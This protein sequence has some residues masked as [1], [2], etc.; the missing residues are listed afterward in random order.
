[1][2]FVRP[3]TDPMKA[4][5]GLQLEL[6]QTQAGPK[7]NLVTNQ[8]RTKYEPSTNQVKDLIL[9]VSDNYLSLGD[10][11]RLCGLKSRMRFR[12]TYILPAL[13]ENAIERKYPDIPNHPRQQY[14]LTEQAKAWKNNRK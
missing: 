13:K 1:M 10:M 11:M 12:T 6:R 8:V 2:T 3:V 9:S 14:R 5:V 4:P 7:S